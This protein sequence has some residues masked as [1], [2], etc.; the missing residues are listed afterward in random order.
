MNKLITLQDITQRSES[1]SANG[2]GSSKSGARGRDVERLA[3]IVFDNDRPTKPRGCNPNK[4]AGWHDHRNDERV[5]ECKS[6][7]NRYK[8]TGPH[9][10]FRIWR[11]NHDKLLHNTRNIDKIGTYFFLVYEITDYE[12]A[13]RDFVDAQVNHRSDYFQREDVKVENAEREIGKICVSVEVIDRLIDNWT[14][15]THKNMGLQEVRDITWTKLLKEL[16][17]DERQFRE[18]PMIKYN[19]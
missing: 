17:V 14:K 1:D 12:I 6:C 19:M 18:K 16:D 4:S 15:V 2:Y 13:H 9:G 7:I 8:S 3:R 11:E 5:V 10:T